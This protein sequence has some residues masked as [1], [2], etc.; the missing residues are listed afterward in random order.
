MDDEL[1]RLSETLNRM[2]DRLEGSFNRNRQFTADASH[3]LRAPLT[4]IQSAAEFEL[5][6]CSTPFAKSCESPSELP[7][8]SISCSAWLDRMPTSSR[9]NQVGLA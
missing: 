9:L 6:R 3:E 1:Q 2:L 7:N 8:S 5:R 4:L